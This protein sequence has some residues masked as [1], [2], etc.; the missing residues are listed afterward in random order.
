MITMRTWKV[1]IVTPRS[2]LASPSERGSVATARGS[3]FA[4][5]MRQVKAAGLER[6]TGYYLTTIAVT[7]GVLAAAWTVFV[8]VGDSW[9]QL[10]VAA[11]LAVVFT[12]I[13]FLGHDRPQRLR[14]LPGRLRPRRAEL[15]GRT[16]PVLQH[17][18]TQP[19]PL[20]ATR[21]GVLPPARPHLLRDHPVAL[22]RPGH[23]HQVGRPLRANPAG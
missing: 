11:F 16:P 2:T 1:R 14:Q 13:E 23:L 3:D 10:A 7:G 6:R 19:A 5:L 22:Q 8:V 12:Q 15:P 4:D 17:A 21:P 9:W 18:P 20:R